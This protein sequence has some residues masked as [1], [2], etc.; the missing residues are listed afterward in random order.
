MLT[1]MSRMR[2]ISG[3]VLP[4]AT[5]CITSASRGVSPRVCSNATKLASLPLPRPLAEGGEYTL[6]LTVVGDRIYGR[7]NDLDTGPVTDT[8][9]QEGAMGIWSGGN[10]IRDIEYLSLDGLTEAAARKAAGLEGK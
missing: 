5:Q 1:L 9:L 3:F 2:A 6:Q 8:R 10:P 7:M 4:S